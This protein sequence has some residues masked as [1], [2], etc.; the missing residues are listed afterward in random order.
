MRRWLVE[1]TGEVRVPRMGEY[2]L[3]FMQEM[4]IAYCNF[5]TGDT[6]ILRVTEITDCEIDW[7]P[8]TEKTPLSDRFDEWNY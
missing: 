2:F 8:I 3:N 4:S 5:R 7:F 1:E 6:P